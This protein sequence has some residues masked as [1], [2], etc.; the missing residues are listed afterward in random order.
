MECIREAE[1]AESATKDANHAVSSQH[2]EVEAARKSLEDVEKHISETQ[3]VL[4]G[5][6]QHSAALRAIQGLAQALQDVT[7]G[8][9]EREGAARAKR[10]R[11]AVAQSDEQGAQAAFE[12][13]ATAFQREQECIAIV[14]TS[15]RHAEQV[16]PTIHD[17]GCHS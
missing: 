11:V 15:V 1:R 4:L 16:F 10:R 3:N 13:T 12:S 17:I 2:H 5:L 14:E 6:A 9:A 7:G 8:A